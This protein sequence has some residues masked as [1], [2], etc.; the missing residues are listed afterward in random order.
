MSP[1][2]PEPVE[3]NPEELRRKFCG[4]TLTTCHI[5][6]YKSQGR[7]GEGEV[8]SHHPNP[9]TMFHHAPILH[10][11]YRSGVETPEKVSFLHLGFAPGVPENGSL[12]DD[13]FQSRCEL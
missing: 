2:N 3:P 9:R 4:V 6:A 10:K 8:T 11:D 5:T 1:A 12:T 13:G 7:S